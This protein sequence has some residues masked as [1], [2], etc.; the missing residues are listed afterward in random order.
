MINHHNYSILLNLSVGATMAGSKWSQVCRG[1]DRLMNNLGENDLV[2]CLL[3][4]SKIK[5]VPK[6]EMSD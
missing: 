3:F 2:T 1:V 6:I 4:N 5:L